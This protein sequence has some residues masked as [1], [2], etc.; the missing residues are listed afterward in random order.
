MQFI[1]VFSTDKR[2]E[3]LLSQI[4]VQFDEL[5]ANARSH[6]QDYVDLL[7]KSGESELDASCFIELCCLKSEQSAKKQ[8]IKRKLNYNIAKLERELID[9]EQLFQTTER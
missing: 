7:M 4:G 8:I 3:M 5:T 2:Y 6:V 1:V 9:S